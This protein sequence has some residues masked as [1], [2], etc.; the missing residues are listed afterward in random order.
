MQLLSAPL[1]SAR[2]ALLLATA[3]FGGCAAAHQMTA[4][5]DDYA[6]YRSANTAPSVE[7]KLALSW[8]YLRSMPQ[9]RFRREVRTWFV[10]AEARYFARAQSS[11]AKL[12]AYL[13][14]LPNGPHAEQAAERLAELVLSE[15][16]ERRREERLLE[17]AHDVEE[18]LA[19][20][21]TM[22][23]AF[24]RTT[25]DWV[26]RLVAIESWGQPTTELHHE[27][28]YHFRLTEP[29]G[30]CGASRCI[31]ALGMHYA[32]PEQKRL[33][34]R[35]AVFDVQFDLAQGGVIAARITGPELFSRLGEALGLAPV[36]PND[37]QARAEAIARA[38]T[39]IAGAAESSLPAAQCAREAVSP[40]A[41]ARQC[42]GIR[43]AMIVAATPDEEDRI[44]VAPLG[45]P[46]EP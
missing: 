11:P 14:A 28:I 36:P 18:R 26:T 8:Q 29:E 31:K 24:A 20:A 32:I 25:R 5:S 3:L 34:P 23:D 10:A 43:L 35:Q 9:G 19:D 30:R 2:A 6:L 40:V 42:R 39:L 41:L 37:P 13:Q 22:R 46:E 7:R 44:E 4:S 16:Y 45:A 15:R 21:A 17:E 33:V 38:A 1:M 27:T 12:E